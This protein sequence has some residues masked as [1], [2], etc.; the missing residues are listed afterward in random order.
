MKKILSLVLVWI[1]L[2]G[3]LVGC[4]SAHEAG[5][6]PV[7]TAKNWIE[8]QI[9]KNT[10]FSFDY[11]GKAYAEHIKAWEKTVEEK[12]NAWVVTYTNG[13]VVAW[14][15]ITLDDE[16]AAVE[17]TNY[18]KNNGSADSFVISNILAINSVVQVE[19]PMLTTAEGSDSLASDFQPIFVNLTE[20]ESFK[21]ASMGGR[22]SHGAFPYF[23]ISNGEY[24]IIGGI[25][26]TGNWKADFTNEAN[27][28]RIQ[29]GMQ[30]TR[31]SLHAG[32]QMRTP[33]VMLQFFK[34]DQDAG[35][36]A[37][38]QLVLKSYTPSDASGEP[39][40]KAMMSIG[41]SSVAGYGID[42][43]LNQVAFFEAIN[44][45]YDSL[46]IDAGWYGDI[47]GDNL[48]TGVWREQVGNWY[49]IPEAYPDG[50][51]R[52]LGDYLASQDK[53]FVLW[54][55]PER[56]VY[57]TKLTVEHPEWFISDEDNPKQEFMLYN[58][59][60]DEA[61]DY[62][63]DMI[64]TII[65][66]SKVTWYRQDANFQPD[67]RW[68]T[69]D[70]AEGENRVGITEIKYITNEYRFLDGLVEMN[71]GLMID[72]CASGGRRLDLEM[73]KRTIPLWNSDYTTHPDT[74]TA[75]GNRALCYNLTWWLPIHAGGGANVTAWDT[76]Y[77][78]R[79]AMMSGMQINIDSTKLG[80]VRNTLIEQYYTCRDFMTG[81][82]YILQQGFDKEI[83][84]KDACYEFYMADQ[85]KGYLMAFRPEN[86]KTESN[87]Y[88]LKGL[89]AT[90]T[91]EL[92]VAD[93]GDKLTMTGE[94]LMTDGLKVTYPRAN[95]SL[96]IYINKI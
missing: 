26:W 70:K 89:D 38:R 20:E 29:A 58:L 91:Y 6:D 65:K 30:E 57:G 60:I 74:A 82:Y 95:L 88:R 40:K 90:A 46:W 18:F 37:F 32:E 54:F 41:V 50:N 2:I 31:I 36:N 9:K 53:E 7:A 72:S 44:I 68:H 51:A 1:L 96:L 81:D 8:T 39:I 22:S 16:M 14:S 61:C 69:A 34:G 83:D 86:C 49:F 11:D 17:W 71:P 24:G 15:E 12:E 62:L 80:V 42:E 87:S 79:A 33:M 3:A 92:E 47:K 48:N 66:D 28:V 77:R 56:A 4:G 55:E 93:T 43:L 45:Q 78:F 59:A 25:G 94:Q 5:D 13:D 10:L 19:N 85:G 21:M 73:M 63:I 64:G 23:D 84:T 67:S 35:H 52:E 27:G 75:D 76:I